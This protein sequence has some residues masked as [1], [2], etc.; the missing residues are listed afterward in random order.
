MNKISK[1]EGKV[2][3]AKNMQQSR[4]NAYFQNLR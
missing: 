2:V 1:V 4:D 3:K